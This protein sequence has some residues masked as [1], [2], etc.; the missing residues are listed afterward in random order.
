MKDFLF[1]LRVDA[2][3]EAHGVKVFQIELLVR[4]EWCILR[5]LDF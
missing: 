5:R 2:A 4:L 3:R 1:V